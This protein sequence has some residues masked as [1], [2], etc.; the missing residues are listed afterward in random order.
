MF[1]RHGTIEL[2]RSLQLAS[3]TTVAPNVINGMITPRIASKVGR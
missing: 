1:G 3:E 2:C